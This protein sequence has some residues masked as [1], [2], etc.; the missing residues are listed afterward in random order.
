MKRVLFTLLCATVCMVEANAQ[1]QVPQVTTTWPT[2]PTDGTLLKFNE[3]VHDFGTINEG[4]KVTYDFEFTNVGQKSVSLTGVKSPCG[5]T[6][7]QWTHEIVPAG[8]KGTITVTFNTAGRPGK[9]EKT[10]T[11]NTDADPKPELIRITGFV[12]P[13][14]QQDPP[15]LSES[16]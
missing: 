4:P 14:P 8:G 11:V 5:C 16:H 7:A 9:L 2:P 6:V 15:A 13:K 10:L 12:T 3:D 1:E